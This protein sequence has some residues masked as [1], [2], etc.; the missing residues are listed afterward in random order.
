MKRLLGI[1]VVCMLLSYLTFIE[2]ASSMQCD[3]NSPV[4]YEC[5]RLKSLLNEYY[6]NYL[7]VPLEISKTQRQISLG[8]EYYANYLEDIQFCSKEIYSQ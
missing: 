2:T 5:Y 3:D 8:N 6:S 1:F 4:S 7:T